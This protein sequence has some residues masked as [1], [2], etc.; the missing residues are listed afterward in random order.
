LEYLDSHWLDMDQK[1]WLRD[2][3]FPHIDSEIM[4]Q[5]LNE[6]CKEKLAQINL[7]KQTTQDELSDTLSVDVVKHCLHSYI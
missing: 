7:E 6:L 4:P 2:F 5:E 3:L 1:P